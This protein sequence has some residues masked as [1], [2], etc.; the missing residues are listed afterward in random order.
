[1]KIAD[2]KTTVIFLPHL[3]GY[4]DAT[5]RHPEKGYTV[6][7]VHIITD[8]GQ[9][10]LAPGRGGIITRELVEGNLKK[11]LLGRD[12]L[13]TERLWDDM[14]WR[15]RGVGRKGV[16]FCALSAVD[17]ALW[18]LKAK[19]FG[20]SRYKLLGQH[21]DS[22]PVYGSGGWTHFSIDELVEEMT[23]FV[24][25]GMTAVKM[26]VGKDFGSCEQEDLRRLQAV[27][28]AVGDD[29]E[30]YVDANGGY[31]P[32]QAVRIAR[33]FEQYG[34]RWFEEPVFADDIPGLA[35][36]ARAID[37]PVASGEHEYT[38][39][40]FR[41]L[42]TSG[43]ADILQPNAGRVGG[44]T[45]WLKISHMVQAFNLQIAPHGEQ[46][47]HLH[48]ACATPNLKR[49]EYLRFLEEAGRILYKD[50][51]EPKDGMWSPDPDKPGLGLELR[52]EAIEQYA[53][54]FRGHHT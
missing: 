8:T 39:Y 53:V 30:I 19:M 22:V 18:D 6:C 4:Q 37:I 32:K 52:P 23:G 1:M 25:M 50:Y 38:K 48:L 42:I 26:K 36:V 35:S 9:E 29:V 41:D 47:T 21:T 17:I 54:K 43:G 51:P 20:L 10:G 13:Q 3:G 2:I 31:Y 14:F 15:L 44:I 16:A 45:E 46:L 5:V 27:R 28:E 11:I 49:V 7:F 33:E 12:P 34:V 24:E 40:G